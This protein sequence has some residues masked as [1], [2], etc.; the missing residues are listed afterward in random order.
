MTTEDF[1]RKLTAVFSADVAGYSRLMGD[2]EAETVK[3]L[4]TYKGVISSL[5]KQHRGRVVDSTGDN[6][7]AEFGSV[8]DAVQCA[9]AV[10]KELQTRNSDLPEERK[11]LFRIGINLGDV[12]EEQDRLYG[13]GVNIAARLEALADPGGICVSKTAFD[14]I[15]S[16]LP[17]GYEFLGEQEVKNIAKPVGAYKVLMETRV[18]GAKVKKTSTEIPFWRRKAV[19]S[20]GILAVLVII[21]GLVWNFYFR[22]PPMKVASKAKTEY[23]P[24]EK[25]IP[26]TA[27]KPSIAVLPFTNM[28]GDKEQEYFSD[29]ISEDI[30]TNLSK[31]SGLI[32]LS[33][34]SSFIYKGKQVKIEDVAKDLGVRY[35][36][37]G[38]VRRGGNKVR[39]TAQL[40][41]GQTE[42]HLWADS[43]DKELK[44]IFSVQD[45]I[46]RRVVSELAVALTATE[47]E[48][49]A[50][51]HT[52]N[53]E[54]YDLY[55]R[56]R[57]AL[58]SGVS[59]EGD[60]KAKELAQKCIE[61]DPEFAG[62]YEIL[63]VV[64]SRGVR[65]GF[66]TSPKEDLGKAYDL[67]QKGVSVDDTFAE[68]YIALASALLMKKRHDDA[69]TAA[70][71]ATRIQPGSS[72]AHLYLGFF[73]HWAGRGKEA[74]EEVKK[75]IQLNPKFL[76]G[77]DPSYLSFL[78]FANFTAG[79]YQEASKAMR[80]SIERYGPAVPRYPFLIASYILSGREEE[81]KETVQRLLK[82]YPKF[83]LSRWKYGRTYKN[84]E[85]VDRLYNALQ[86]A[87]LK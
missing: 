33:R 19:L 29:G 48:R 76:E 21:A 58:Y 47:D 22:K 27:D 81:A 68:N 4:E 55:L 49:Q 14:H 74:V 37:E 80:T 20:I 39:V 2:N 1:K 69:V 50:R 78:G 41:D 59:K 61:L 71:N 46:T 85:D 75:A 3:T 30:I 38:S 65:F 11:M 77:A 10:Q 42:Q 66:S 23:K 5:I 8:V 7:L 63:S 60:R 32:V 44:D 86:K 13:D 87:G 43:Y 18:V 25:S 67:A 83:S 28:S 45:Q 64:L 17:L 6:L 16:K 54:A 72:Y 31:I 82:T 34:N 9:V 73:L 70:M 57:K 40:I 53:F 35:V 26:K 36:L 24:S 84:P 79:F 15:E 12:I 56:A 62:G 51:R 52:E